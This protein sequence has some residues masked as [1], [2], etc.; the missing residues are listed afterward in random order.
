MSLTLA[1][2]DL[3]IYDNDTIHRVWCGRSSSET[4]DSP[5][6]LRR[7]IVALVEENERLTEENDVLNNCN[8]IPL[9][10]LFEGA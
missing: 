2:N 9:H 4:V 7:M 1:D 5:S 3:F 8:K 6:V 10:E